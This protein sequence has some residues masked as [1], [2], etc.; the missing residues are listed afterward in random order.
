V[1]CDELNQVAAGTA[2]FDYDSLA[3]LGGRSAVGPVIVHR[4]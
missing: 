3:G 4:K 1:T 2:M